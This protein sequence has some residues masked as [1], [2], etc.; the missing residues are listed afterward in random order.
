MQLEKEKVYN[1]QI[2]APILKRKSS[3]FG[4][5]QF[6]SSGTNNSNAA[7]VAQFHSH[8]HHLQINCAPNAQQIHLTHYN[9][10][11]NPTSAAGTTPTT[12]NLITGQQFQQHHAQHGYNV[13]VTGAP[14]RP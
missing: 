1:R 5:G 4:L 14:G 13:C 3:R 9:V 7:N 11:T 2:S 12:P 10:G 6:L 8:Y